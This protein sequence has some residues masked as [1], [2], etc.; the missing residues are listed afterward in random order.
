MYEQ[1]FVDRSLDAIPIQEKQVLTRIECVV[2]CE[3]TPICNAFA[4]N[5]TRTNQHFNCALHGSGFDKFESN[6]I[7]A[8][9]VQYWDK[10]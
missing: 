8:P 6:F 9:G 10:H 5:T 2:A 7:D 3:K 1:R 4:L